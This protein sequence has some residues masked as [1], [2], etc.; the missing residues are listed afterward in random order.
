MLSLPHQRG[1]LGSSISKAG[2]FN[3]V[4]PLANKHS[5]S[6]LSIDFTDKFKSWRC[7]HHCLKSRCELGAFS[8]VKEVNATKCCR[9]YD[10]IGQKFAI[11]ATLGYFLLHQLLPKQ[12]VFT[13]SLL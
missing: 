12:A 11:S 3:K 5:R 6:K 1:F 4:W 8:I 7:Y 10:Q 9:V 2:L 13:H